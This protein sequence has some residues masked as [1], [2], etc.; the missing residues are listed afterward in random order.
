MI[1]LGKSQINE[2][3]NKMKAQTQNSKFCKKEME[4]KYGIDISLKLQ[5]AYQRRNIQCWQNYHLLKICSDY[6]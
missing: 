3:K 5:G 2:C 4:N 6:I 1:F